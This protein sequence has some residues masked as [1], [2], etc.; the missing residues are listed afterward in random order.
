MIRAL[1]SLFLGLL[2]VGGCSMRNPF[3]ASNP[4]RDRMVYPQSTPAEMVFVGVRNDGSVIEDL[5]ADPEDETAG[6]PHV[7]ASVTP[8][9]ADSEAIEV[10]EDASPASQP[11]SE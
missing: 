4:E 2:L 7:T 6:P 1:F 8:P 3:R 5:D 9:P 11:A 10:I